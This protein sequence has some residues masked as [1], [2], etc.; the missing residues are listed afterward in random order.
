[1]RASRDELR[2]E[3]IEIVGVGGLDTAATAG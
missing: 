2:S 3:D 1:V